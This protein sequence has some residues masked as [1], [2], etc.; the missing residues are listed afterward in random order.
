MRYHGSD[1]EN[2]PAEAKE[3]TAELNLPTEEVA[4]LKQF[5]NQPDI[6]AAVQAAMREYL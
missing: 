6:A 1:R 5:T 4:E 2:A 3:I